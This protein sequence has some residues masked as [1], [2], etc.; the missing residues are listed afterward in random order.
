MTAYEFGKMCAEEGD[1]FCPET[2]FVSATQMGMYA[3]GFLS[4]KPDNQAALSFTGQTF[5]SRL[6]E[7]RAADLAA[8]EA[9]YTSRPGYDF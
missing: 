6:A 8:D 1:P 3:Q 7:L 5:H 4:V 9:Q 2:S